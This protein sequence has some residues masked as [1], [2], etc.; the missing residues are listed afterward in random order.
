MLDLIDLYAKLMTMTWLDD[1]PEGV[2]MTPQ[3]MNELGEVVTR[4]VT[5]PED[6][7]TIR[8]EWT[9]GGHRSPVVEYRETKVLQLP[10]TG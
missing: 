4:F 7:E 9:H 5:D 10:A 2:T 6:Q 1:D 3:L 8:G